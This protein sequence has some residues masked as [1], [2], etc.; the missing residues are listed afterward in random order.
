V[1]DDQH[2]ALGVRAAQVT[3]LNTDMPVNTVRNITV[4]P[5]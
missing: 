5:A 2:P 3:Q 1:D 4:A